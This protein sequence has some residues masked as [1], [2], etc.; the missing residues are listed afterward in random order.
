MTSNDINW[1]SEIEWTHVKSNGMNSNQLE[2]DE[3]KWHEVTPT[4]ITCHQVK[5]PETI[6]TNCNT[7]VSSDIQWC[8]LK[9]YEINWNLNWSRMKLSESKWNQMNP[10]EINWKLVKSFDITEHEMNTIKCNEVKLNQ[11]Q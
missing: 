4:E 3:I 2:P 8:R 7:V 6:W 10:S 11:L 1:N 5:R 9:H